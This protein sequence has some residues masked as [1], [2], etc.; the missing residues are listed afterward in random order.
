LEAAAESLRTAEALLITAGAGLGVDSGLPDFRGSRGFW[1]AYP[2]YARLGI[3][4]IE[5]ASPETLHDD[6]ALVWGFYEHRRL[7]Y[8]DTQP[9]GGY[10]ILKKLAETRSSFVFTSNVDGHFF[11]AGFSESQVVE[12]HGSIHHLQCAKPC[13]NVL[14]PAADTRLIVD[15][16]S[17]RAAGTFPRC[18]SC[19]N[20]ARP[21]V[22]L[23]GDDAWVGVR[24]AAQLARYASWLE[25]IRGKRLVVLELGAGT[26]IPTVR[27]E[28]RNVAATHQGT[29]IRINPR[30]CA[31]QPG[32]GISLPGTALEI[33]LALSDR[34]LPK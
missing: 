15:P 25:Q 11:R 13:D 21:N 23:F 27:M 31:L 5:L 33:L 1:N 9:H 6:A 8:R 30:D 32:T 24:A 10:L 22:L 28:G 2:P 12:C 16:A 18:E 17:L 34:L 20:L 3:E 4:F 26:D 29:F 14:W 19:G 7:L